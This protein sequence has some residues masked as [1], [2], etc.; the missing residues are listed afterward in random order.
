MTGNELLR[1][2]K[3]LG[4]EHGVVVNFDAAHGDGSHGTLY[5]GSRRTTLKD[6][7]EDIGRGLLHKMLADLGLT[8]RELN[9]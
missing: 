9:Q 1:K 2:I 7:K 4:R 8:V 3:R 6:R 5:Y